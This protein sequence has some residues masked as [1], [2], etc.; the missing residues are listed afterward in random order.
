[1]TATISNEGLA[2]VGL[3]ETAV[4]DKPTRM[5]RTGSK[6]AML[7]A[8]LGRE[9]GATVEEMAAAPGWPVSGVLSGA[10]SGDQVGEG[11]RAGAGVSASV[12]S[13]F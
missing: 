7:V 2:A 4:A 11:R 6:L 5:P 8:L 10:L 3:E 13:G 1:M 9:E 12:R